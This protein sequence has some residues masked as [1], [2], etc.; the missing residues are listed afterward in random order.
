MKKILG[1]LIIALFL[2]SCRYMDA[3]DTVEEIPSAAEYQITETQS[4]DGDVS[5]L[6]D[7]WIGYY[8][9]SGVLPRD[10][11]ADIEF[12]IYQEDGEFQGYLNMGGFCSETTNGETIQL[13]SER[14][15]LTEIRGN[16]EL[17][18]VYFLEDFSE[19]TRQGDMFDVF[20]KG[21]LLFALE[22]AGSEI[23][24]VWEEMYLEQDQNSWKQGFVQMDQLIALQLVNR[25]DKEFFI[26]ANGFSLEEK[27]FHQY[28]DEDGILQMD[29]YYDMEQESGIGV[30]YGKVQEQ[31]IMS[32]FQVNGWEQKV[33][34]D[35]KFS[36][37]KEEEDGSER[38]GYEEKCTY[39]EWG[40][41]TYFCSEGMI[42]GWGEPYWGKIIEIEFLYREDGTIQKKKSYYNSRL[43]GTTRQSE[44]YL[45]DTEERLVYVSAYITHGYLEDY[46]IYEGDS[47]KPAYCLILDHMGWD[48]AAANFIKYIP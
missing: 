34:K 31:E 48:A 12:F 13:R 5:E 41:L 27:L 20:Q 45:Y 4:A 3:A 40:Q 25:K 46:Y 28:F 7:G 17:I 2:T 11:Y 32:G 23:C 44:T 16:Q 33:W 39:N 15:M 38:E 26:K 22:K 14:R 24:P 18:K 9:Y 37:K 19:E 21:Q 42:T 36:V 43:F 29:L 6:L 30:F 47:L 10:G 35:N 1:V 8:T